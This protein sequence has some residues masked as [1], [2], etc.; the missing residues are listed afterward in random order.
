MECSEERNGLRTVGM[1]LITVILLMTGMAAKGRVK[2][3]AVIATGMVVQRNVPIKLWGKADG[4]ETVVAGIRKADE[5]TPKEAQTTADYSG[6]WTL[7]LPPVEAGG[8]YVITINEKVIDNV[9]C[10]DVYLC[11]GQSNMELPVRRVMD[12]FADE[13]ASYS[14][15]RIREFRVPSTYEFHSPIEDLE[16][17]EWKPT[18][19]ENVMNFSALGHFFAKELYSRTGVP[20]GIINSSWGGTPI[21]AWI[22]EESLRGVSPRSINEKRLYEDD[23]YRGHIKKLE[24]E[25]FK[26]WGEAL[27]SGDPGMN[28]AI[29]WYEPRF[30]DSDWETVDI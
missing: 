14:N 13:I 24:A 3:P 1:T 15:D 11:S 2:L 4:G 23:A 5:K 22:S 7:E 19:S 20:V 26:R 21:E 10:G 27:F 12:M 9:L 28:G 6:R 29:K 8:P 16:T 17:G 18:T 25:N 30:D